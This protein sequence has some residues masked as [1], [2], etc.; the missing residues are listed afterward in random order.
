MP[1][2]EWHR[3]VRHEVGHVL[4]ALHEQQRP[5]VVARLDPAK[6]IAAFQRSQGWSEQ[7]IRDQILTRSTCRRPSIPTR[8]IG[9]S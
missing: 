5:E 1:E 6:V 9:R 7:E 3:V 8:M 4:G 2:S